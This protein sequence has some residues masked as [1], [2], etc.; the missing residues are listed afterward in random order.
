MAGVTMIAFGVVFVL[1]LGEIDL[2]IG[3]S[4]IAAVARRVVA[5]ARGRGPEDYPVGSRSLDRSSSS[6]AIGASQ[7]IMS[8]VIGVPSFVVT[9]A[10]LLDLAGRAQS[11]LG[12]TGTINVRTTESTTSRDLY[13]PRS[14]AGSSPSMPPR[15]MRSLDVLGAIR[16]RRAGLPAGRSSSSRPRCSR[17]LPCSPW[18]SST[19]A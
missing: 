10:G 18:R 9:L 4:G 13:S 5:A 19:A 14:R 3:S 7:G 8:R 6:R 17:P 11:V 12:T 15:C 2:S 16:R 1:L